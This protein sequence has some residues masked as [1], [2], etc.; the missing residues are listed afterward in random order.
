MQRVETAQAE[1]KQRSVLC[2]LNWTRLVQVRLAIAQ[3]FDHPMSH[4]CF[5]EIES[6]EIDFAPGYRSTASLLAGWLAAQLHWT[7]EENAKD[8]ALIFRDRLRKTIQVSLGGKAGEPISR[9]VVKC[10]SAEFRVSHSVNADL[11]DVAIE[12]S[13]AE[14]KCL[15]PAGSNDPVRLMSEELMRGGPHRVYLRAMNSVRS[16]L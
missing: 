2:D 6:V 1:A 15:M 13:D 3:F 5:G 4:H 10:R 9:C 14:R 7:L 16:L 11:L 8:N 12:G